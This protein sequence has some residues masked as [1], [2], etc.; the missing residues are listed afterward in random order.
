MNISQKMAAT[1]G[2]PFAFD[3]RRLAIA[4]DFVDA[5]RNL[6]FVTAPKSK[7]I[8]RS[9]SPFATRTAMAIPHNLGLSGHAEFDCATKAFSDV[10]WMVVHDTLRQGSMLSA[11]ILTACP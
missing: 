5:F 4:S 6:N 7:C 3:L 1:N 9:S 2:A 8:Y 10:R 11:G